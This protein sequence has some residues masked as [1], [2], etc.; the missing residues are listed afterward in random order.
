MDD[1]EFQIT[2][3][4]AYILANQLRGLEDRMSKGRHDDGSYHAAAKN[5]N[6]ILKKAKDILKA[7]N[8]MS[9]SIKHLCEY[10]PSDGM[11]HGEYDQ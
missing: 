2:A 7:D 8:S 10:E 1:S 11:V 4:E 6:A 5:Y 3:K 9:H